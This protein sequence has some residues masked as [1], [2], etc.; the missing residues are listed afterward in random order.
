MRKGSSICYCYIYC[1]VACCPVWYAW[2]NADTLVVQFN[3]IY[4]YETTKESF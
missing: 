1:S 2:C 3:G 4:L